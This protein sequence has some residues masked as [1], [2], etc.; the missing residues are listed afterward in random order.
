MD[1]ED[2]VTPKKPS[3][4]FERS[5]S[6]DFRRIDVRFRDD[7]GATEDFWFEFS[8][9]TMSPDD[10]IAL[11]LS[12]LCGR[13]F[14]AIHFDFPISTRAVRQLQEFTLAK[15]TAVATREPSTPA[16]RSG[17]TLSFSGG[18]DSLAAMCL[19]PTDTHL[20]SMDFGGRFSR[21]RAF[22]E[23]FPTLRVSTNVL[24]TGLHRNSWSFMGIG[25][26]LSA[27]HTR[28][29]FH[30]F[31][32]IL[33][34][35]PDNMR[36]NPANAKNAAFPPF[37]AAG[38]Q[39]APFV[40]G[41]TEIGTLIVL[42]KYM[43]DHIAASLT[44]LATPGEEKLYRK[45]VLTNVVA[46]RLGISIPLQETPKPP[47]PHFRYGQNFALDLLSLYVARYAG[48]ETASGLVADI[49]GEAVTLAKKLSMTFFERANTTLLSNFPA[50]LM[51]GLAD[52]LSRAD[53]SFYTETDWVEYAQV[54]AFLAQYHSSVAT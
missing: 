4:R 13:N 11:A 34:A 7:G 6:S 36:V 54:R 10:N 31:G 48:E 2:S 49:P 35:G 12:T 52:K 28:S 18:F 25:A 21:E 32:S 39:N 29:E 37:K 3:C 22:F 17:T 30:T 45:Q 40:A 50:P 23:T 33:E 14:S 53:I 38:Y 46:E 16:P 41:L 44:S 26:I 47:K 1:L 42:A 5:L 8:R 9:P 24:E 20:V 43:P 19:M 51:G 15:I 27:E